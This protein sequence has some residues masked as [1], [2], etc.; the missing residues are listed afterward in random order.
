[1]KAVDKVIAWRNG[2][3]ALVSINKVAQHRA[4][5]LLGWVTVCR[6]VYHLGI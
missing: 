1:V 4:K 5:L 3:V 6:K 2:C